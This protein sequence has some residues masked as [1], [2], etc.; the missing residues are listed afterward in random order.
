MKR[1]LCLLLCTVMI[2]GMFTAC[3]EK[4]PGKNPT[5]EKLDISFPYTGDPITISY[6]DVDYRNDAR[7]YDGI[8]DEKLQKM[9]G[10]VVFEYNLVPESDFESQYRLRAAVGD[11]SDI[12]VGLNGQSIANTY[13]DTGYLLN[14]AD[15]LEYMPNYCK[16]AEKYGNVFSYG[17][18]GGIY[19]VTQVLQQNYF[20]FNWTWNNYYTVNYGIEKPETMEELLEAFRAA[21]KINPN[22]Y[23]FMSWPNGWLQQL[24]I[25]YLGLR[26]FC[27]TLD[28][29]CTLEY[30]WE[31]THEFVYP[32]L[33][34]GAKEMIE[35][36][37]ICYE[38]EL[39]PP[40][41]LTMTQENCNNIIMG[42]GDGWLAYGSWPVPGDFD[43]MTPQVQKEHPGYS[44]EYMLTPRWSEGRNKA[45]LYPNVEEGS[46]PG[47]ISVN[48]D[49]ENPEFIC[50]LIDFMIS[51]QVDELVNWGIEGETFE[52]DE[53]GNRKFLDDVRTRANRLGT[54]D[55]EKDYSLYT[56]INYKQFSWMSA[57]TTTWDAQNM[58]TLGE[59]WLPIWEGIQQYGAEHP[60]VVISRGIADVQYTVDEIEELSI[61][62]GRANTYCAEMLTAFVTGKRPMSEWDQA[63]AELKEV[64]NLDRVLEIANGNKDTWKPIINN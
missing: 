2:M 49:V 40:D 30:D 38:E 10:N 23:P 52:I 64:G 34:D 36:L 22:S 47:A 33:Q 19:A 4:K 27:V 15:Y 50:A 14:F 6:F 12:N 58:V 3:S 7:T 9:I 39:I 28:G 42:S 51:D 32:I 53:N 26:P 13:G 48:A 60:E 8:I 31:D 21:K 62:L 25:S 29:G 63:I 37:H 24:V 5:G 61:L 46:A 44:V 17:E 54:I 59:S 57:S 45:Y 43:A 1:I 16:L 11:L 35:F 55:L 18:D 20:C 56:H 41:F